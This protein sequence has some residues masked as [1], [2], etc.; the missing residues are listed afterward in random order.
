MIL[1]VNFV[2]E[3]GTS[4]LG[5]PYA[6]S[7]SRRMMDS[8]RSSVKDNRIKHPDGTNET[9]QASEVQRGAHT[10]KQPPIATLIATP[11]GANERTGNAHLPATGLHGLKEAAAPTT[12]QKPDAQPDHPHASFRT[13]EVHPTASISTG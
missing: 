12:F 6:S 11:A 1:N 7:N 5:A 13:T 3:S 4:N 8:I 9:V 2:V 10:I